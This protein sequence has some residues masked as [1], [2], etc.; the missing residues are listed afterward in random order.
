MISKSIVSSCGDIKHSLTRYLINKKVRFL[1]TFKQT[2]HVILLNLYNIVRMICESDWMLSQRDCVLMCCLWC[3]EMA[4][5]CKYVQICKE[6]MHLWEEGSELTMFVPQ[7][8]CPT[9]MNKT[10][11]IL[12]PWQLIL[13]KSLNSIVTYAPWVLLWK[14]FWSC[15]HPFFCLPIH[16]L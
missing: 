15:C 6:I 13:Q 9:L 5:M 1:F 12:I 11:S 10:Y 4:N 14:T 7:I 16:S 8:P 2:Y 3:V